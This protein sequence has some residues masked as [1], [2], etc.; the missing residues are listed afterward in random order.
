MSPNP[1]KP[2]RN[3]LVW[4]M[5]LLVIAS[6]AGVSAIA[7]NVSLSTVILIVV[8]FAEAGL[9]VLGLIIVQNEQEAKV[10]KLENV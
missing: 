9:I 5:L 2:S 8:A 7:V 1:I 6:F 10:E 3:L 4:G